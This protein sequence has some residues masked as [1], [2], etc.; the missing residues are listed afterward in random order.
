MR[1]ALPAALAAAALLAGCGGDDDTA[2]KAGSRA[3]PAA[4][5][6]TDKIRIADFLY[7]PDPVTVKAGSPIAIANSDDAPHTITADGAKRAFDSGTIL[8]GKSGSVTFST[9]GTFK[10]FC[11]FHPTMKGTVTVTR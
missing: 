8:G 2:A 10:Y 1:H 11:E 4:A 6:A 3:A 9:P 7:E 5:S